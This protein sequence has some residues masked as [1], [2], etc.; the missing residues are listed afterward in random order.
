MIQKSKYTADTD[1]FGGQFFQKPETYFFKCSVHLS[2]YVMAMSECQD[3]YATI[4]ADG[5][6]LNTAYRGLGAKCKFSRYS[7]AKWI[8]NYSPFMKVLEPVHMMTKVPKLQW[9]LTC[10]EVPIDRSLPADG[11]CVLPYPIKDSSVHRVLIDGTF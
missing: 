3:Y 9:S 1:V 4:C 7:H 5:N 6:T 2:A 10:L 11:P 8:D